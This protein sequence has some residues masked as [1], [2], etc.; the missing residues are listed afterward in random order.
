[1]YLREIVDIKIQKNNPT[2]GYSGFHRQSCLNLTLRVLDV[3]GISEVWGGIFSLSQVSA[4][5]WFYTYERPIKAN[6]KFG[7]F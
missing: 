2:R 6:V 4:L 7:I 5:P 3:N 1:M